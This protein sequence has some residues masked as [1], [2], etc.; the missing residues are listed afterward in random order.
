MKT[1][2]KEFWKIEKKRDRYFLSI[3]REISETE[4][5]T[6]LKEHSFSG[7]KKES[8][9]ISKE[10]SFSGTRKEH[11]EFSAREGYF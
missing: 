6:I 10:R 5:L 8:L 11:E 4:A 2:N 7:T 1:K 3:I 9:T